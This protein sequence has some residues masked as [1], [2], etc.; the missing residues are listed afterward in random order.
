MITPPYVIDDRETPR[1]RVHRGTMVDDDVL[2]LE[3]KN[4]FDRSWL[5][6]G[7]ESEIENPH[8]FRTRN[9]GGR[10]IIFQR[11]T[12]GQVR[13]FV[14]SCPHRGMQI[15][16]RGE[17]HGRFLKCFYHGW[18]FNTEGDLV[19]LPGE[20]A[21][22]ENFDRH[23]LCLVRPAKVESFRGF[24]FLS[25]AESIVDLQTYLAGACDIL[26]LFADQSEE[27]MQVIG[28]SHLYAARSNWKLLSENSA[29]GYHALTTHHRYL[30]MLK[31]S[32]KDLSIVFAPGTIANLG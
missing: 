22:G 30:A 19:A 24:V 25:W 2:E 3:R 12:A 32:G 9:V 23:N 31:D 15:E 13:V 16:T 14:N 6:V 26:D 8:D 10:P 29:D 7:H 18:S 28:G 20:E 11:D 1:F 27:G 21:Y 17:G 4:I 5:Y